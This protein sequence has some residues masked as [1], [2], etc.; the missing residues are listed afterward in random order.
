ML[1][2]ATIRAAFSAYS[3][4]EPCA[5]HIFTT[6]SDIVGSSLENSFK[7]PANSELENVKSSLIF[8]F[9]IISKILTFL[10][11]TVDKISFTSESV[12]R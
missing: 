7:I 1:T 12:K 2:I 6:F 3:V 8:A 5:A 11:L 9:N 4:A 10:S